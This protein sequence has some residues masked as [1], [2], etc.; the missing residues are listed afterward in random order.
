MTAQDKTSTCEFVL[1]L[2]IICAETR[3]G[4]FGRHSFE[5]LQ[6]RLQRVQELFGF[7]IEL[8]FKDQQAQ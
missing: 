2:E 1:L 7:L 4:L 8:C 3:I 6:Q 5:R